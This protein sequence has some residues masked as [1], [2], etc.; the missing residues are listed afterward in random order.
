MRL[1]IIGLLLAG[2]GAMAQTRVRAFPV[3]SYITKLNDTTQLVQIVLPDG[4]TLPEKQV[5]LMRGT[6]RNDNADT[7]TKGYGRLQLIK[8]NYYY[9][10]I[11]H[12]NSKKLIEEGDLLYT[13][14]PASNAYDGLFTKL[15]SHYILLQDVYEKDLYDR[16]TI[17]NKFT[18]D[19]EQSL[20][21]S[22]V[23]DIQFTGDY[24]LKNNPDLNKSINS[25]PYKGKNVLNVMTS[26]KAADVQ[27]FLEYMTVRPRL[28]AGHT[29][30]VSEIFATWLTSGAPAVIK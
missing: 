13:E 4:V 18:A 9:F 6:Y 14:A 15:A 30:K 20:I 23:K 3:T 1:L 24:F 5:G 12:N 11:S 21:D 10:S 16:N 27:N 25:G 7:V 26:C 8:G 22:I 17:F 29:W 19:D 28:Y 2:M